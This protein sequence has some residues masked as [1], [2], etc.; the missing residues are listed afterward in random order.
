MNSLIACA[1]CCWGVE[2]ATN[3]HNPSWNTVVVESKAAGY[4]GIELGP[5]GYMPLEE[6]LLIR[7]SKLMVW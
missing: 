7:R 6:S 4:Q 1:P 2:S 3:V 5:F